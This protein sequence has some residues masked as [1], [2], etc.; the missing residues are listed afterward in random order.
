MESNVTRVLVHVAGSRCVGEDRS[1]LFCSVP[2]YN[3][4]RHH[5]QLVVEGLFSLANCLVLHAVIVL[6]RL[7]FGIRNCLSATAREGQRELVLFSMR[8]ACS[9]SVFLERARTCTVR[10]EPVVVRRTSVLRFTM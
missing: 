9:P 10:H 4:S 5:E 8:L 2:L 6:E 7:T 3:I 1:V